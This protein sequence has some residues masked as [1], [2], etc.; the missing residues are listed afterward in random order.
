MSNQ[1]ARLFTGPS[2]TTKITAPPNTKPST[3]AAPTRPQPPLTFS[4]PPTPRPPTATRPQPLPR[5][6]QTLT[7]P[8]QPTQ[9]RPANWTSSSSNEPSPTRRQ[10]PSTQNQ[11]ATK[12]PLPTKPTPNQTQHLERP[13]IPPKP[14]SLSSPP[15]PFPGTPAALN[16]PPKNHRDPPQRTIQ[17]NN[18]GATPPQPPPIRP[19]TLPTN[20]TKIQPPQPP[21]QNLHRNLP[22]PRNS[23]LNH[24]HLPHYTHT[25]LLYSL[26]L[27]SLLPTLRVKGVQS[28]GHERARAHH[29][30]PQLLQGRPSEPCSDCL[31]AL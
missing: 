31:Q 20:L 6:A 10:A 28:N 12:H 21:P 7:T 29:H 30:S 13:K 27:L 26:L 3:S 11:P 5:T 4:A 25:L 17:L 19:P 23:L 18:L 9:I 14:R 8:D 15:T 16:L 22:A 24:T 1:H 2:T